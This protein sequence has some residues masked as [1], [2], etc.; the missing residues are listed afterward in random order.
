MHNIIFI[1]SGSR[2]YFGVFDSKTKKTRLMNH[3]IIVRSRK[4]HI[5]TLS[6]SSASTEV[7]FIRVTHPNTP[8]VIY[9]QILLYVH[10][11]KLSYYII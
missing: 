6:I 9:K 5:P 8:L 7:L 10:Q 2:V 1:F 4:R 3:V 11:S